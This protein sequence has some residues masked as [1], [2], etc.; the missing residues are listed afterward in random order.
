ML[1]VFLIVWIK[2][3]NSLS[4]FIKFI[5]HIIVLPTT[6][7][8]T[9]F[10]TLIIEVRLQHKYSKLSRHFKRHVTIQNMVNLDLLKNKPK[11]FLN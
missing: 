7:W 10:L 5:M 9:N 3:T 4:Y 6:I 2:M 11:I 8:G 1:G